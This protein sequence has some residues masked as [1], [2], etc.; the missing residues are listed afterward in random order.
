M[1]IQRFFQGFHRWLY[2][3][4][5]KPARCSFCD[6]AYITAGPFLEGSSG[7]FICGNCLRLAKTSIESQDDFQTD[8]DVHHSVLQQPQAASSADSPIEHTSSGD[9]CSFCQRDVSGRTF[10]PPDIN[11]VICEDCIL[12]STHLLDRSAISKRTRRYQSAKSFI[13]YLWD[14]MAHSLAFSSEGNDSIPPYDET[15]FL[16]ELKRALGHEGEQLKPNDLKLAY[17]NEEGADWKKVSW[18]LIESI[19]SFDGTSTTTSE[20]LPVVALMCILSDAVRRGASD[21]RGSIDSMIRII[22][23][24]LEQGNE[25]HRLQIM[26]YIFRE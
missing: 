3:E 21:W 25:L 17:K 9:I 4:S 6:E 10:A 22:S 23:Q 5:L 14:D 15:A 24:N 7:A 13:E 11:H 16:Q 18:S 8:G 2:G 12:Y 19:P 20:F 26:Q 1:Q